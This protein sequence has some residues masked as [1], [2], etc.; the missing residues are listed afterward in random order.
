MREE[1]KDPFRLKHMLESSENV[2]KFMDGKTLE[3]LKTDKLLFYGVVKNI[4]IIGEASYK[5]TD[6]L[7]EKIKEIP[8]KK[9]AGM[10]HVLVHEYYHIKP[11]EVFLVYQNE[12]PFLIQQLKKVINNLNN[13]SN[14]L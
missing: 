11:E 14:N 6:S 8:W 9:I 12:I 5:I 2:I 3:D 4:E 13:T 7:K 1:I 10:R